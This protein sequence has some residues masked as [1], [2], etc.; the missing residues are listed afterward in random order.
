MREEERTR[1]RRRGPSKS[2]PQVNLRLEI[3]CTINK[4][5]ESGGGMR[6]EGEE[7]EAVAGRRVKLQRASAGLQT[8]LTL[9]GVVMRSSVSSSWNEQRITVICEKSHRV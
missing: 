7:G 8:A 1:G 4:Q 6:D 2:I 5:G 3:F 9:C